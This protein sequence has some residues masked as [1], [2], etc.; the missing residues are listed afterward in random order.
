MFCIYFSDATQRPSSELLSRRARAVAIRL[1]RVNIELIKVIERQAQEIMLVLPGNLAFCEVRAF[2]KR[3]R[4]I[5]YLS[6]KICRGRL[7]NTIH[8]HTKIRSTQK[9]RESKS[10]AEQNTLAIPEPPT[11]LFRGE[12]DAPEVWFEL[13]KVSMILRERRGY[14]I[15]AH[16]SDCAKQSRYEGT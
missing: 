11:L 12:L 10:E 3:W 8:E 2:G 16:A 4:R 7:S 13:G 5:G 6:D 9:N 15:Q 1:F 14:N